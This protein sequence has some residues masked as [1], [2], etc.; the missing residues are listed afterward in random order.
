VA[1]VDQSPP[2][3]GAFETDHVRARDAA[4]CVET[5]LRRKPV[6]IA[7]GIGVEVALHELRLNESWAINH[8]DFYDVSQAGLD[9]AKAT[10]TE[11]GIVS[12]VSLV[13]SD[14]VD[15]PRKHTT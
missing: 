14:S 3:S 7:L 6:P 13:C 12:K 9:I 1:R 2:R 15:L 8:F 11:T 4:W 5:Q 10:A